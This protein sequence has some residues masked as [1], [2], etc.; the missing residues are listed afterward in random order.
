M[1]DSA[2]VNETVFHDFWDGGG[3]DETKKLV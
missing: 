2:R 1:P 3:L